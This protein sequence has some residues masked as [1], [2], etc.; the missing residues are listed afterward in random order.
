MRQIDFT[1]SEFDQLKYERF[2][3]P[4]LRV[5]K[6]METL[7]L[8][9]NQIPHH[10]I[11]E[12][13]GI[14]ESTLCRYLHS[15]EEGGIVQLKEIHFHQPQ[16]ALA[17]FRSSL[18]FYLEDH[19]PKNAKEAAALIEEITGIK[20]STGQIRTYMKSIGMK[21]RKVGMIPAKAD[22]EK[23]KEF[24][25][26]RIEPTLEEAKKKKGSSIFSMP[27]ILCWLLFLDSCGH[28]PV[29]LSRLQRVENAS[30]FWGR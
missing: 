13:V 10:K 7:L 29:F 24:R 22:S 16:S 5:Q 26:Q 2:H 8:K 28:L 21:C 4:H 19:P 14:S 20:R 18:E 11:C 12:I 6:K 27:L 30:T 9:S 15:F 23:Q 17:L 25:E 1:S 3:H